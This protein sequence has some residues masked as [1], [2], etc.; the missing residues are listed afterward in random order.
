MN[1]ATETLENEQIAESLERQREALDELEQTQESLQQELANAQQQ[2]EQQALTAAGLLVA[3]LLERAK[4]TRDETIRLEE[5][6]IS[7]GKWSRSQLKS[8]QQAAEA[9]REIADSVREAGQDLGSKGVL[10]LC[11]EWRM[12]I[13]DRSDRLANAMRGRG[14]SRSSWQASHCWSSSWPAWRLRIRHRSPLRKR[15]SMAK[16]SP[17][18]VIRPDSNRH[19]RFSRSRCGCYWECSKG[20][21]TR[22]Q[23]LNTLKTQ[24]H[25]LTPDQ[26]AE[27]KQ[28]RDRQKR[29]V[30]TARQ[31][32]RDEAMEML[33]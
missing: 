16:E 27:V 32:V 8:V 22:T 13:L 26:V 25:D 18:A 5:L 21:L 14:H 19:R 33:P 7:S 11:L 1:E 6:R 23:A 9:Q 24:G 20:L 15:A 30:E 28:L 4:S 17:R 2:A 10:N 12:S 29:L 3:S 31:M